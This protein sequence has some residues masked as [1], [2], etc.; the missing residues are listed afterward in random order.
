MF[1]VGEEYDPLFETN[2]TYFND[3]TVKPETSYTYL[4]TSYL[5]SGEE[6]KGVTIDVETPP[7]EISGGDTNVDEESG[8]Y[9]ITWTEPTEGKILVAVGGKEYAVVNAS[10]LKITIPKEDMKFDKLGYPDVTLTPLDENE[11]PIGKPSKPGDMGSVVGD[12]EINLN[13]NNL[14]QMGVGLLGVIG[15]FVLLGLAFL[16]V[17]KLIN[18]VVLAFKGG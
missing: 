12:V 6:T 5:S 13:E 7:V 16:V 8:D 18:S 3:L 4:L 15:G 14:L 1:S 9:V 2:G 17:K 11:V 10:D